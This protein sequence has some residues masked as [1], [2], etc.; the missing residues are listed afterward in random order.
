[1]PCD[2]KNPAVPPTVL[3]LPS[4]AALQRSGSGRTPLLFL[5]GVGGGAWSWEPQVSALDGVTA[6]AWEARGHGAADRVADA[7][8]AD[9]HAD[10]REALDVVAAAGPAFVIGHSMGGL[11]AM[12][13]AAERPEAIRG[14][15]LVDPVY[16]PDGGTHAGG[17]LAALARV[18]L[19]PLV[20]DLERNGAFSRALGRFVFVRSFADRGCMERAWARQRTQIPF[21]YPKMMFEAFDGTAGFP[22]RAFAREFSMPTLLLEPSASAPRFPTLLA[23]LERLDDR[24]THVAVDGGHYLQLD[25]SADDVSRALKDFV[26]RWSQ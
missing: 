12:A 11:L 10:A 21:E 23:D 19:P 4:G 15:C 16:A 24:F 20:R 13:L 2:A 5:H 8:L 14:L 25:R 6:Y 18:A 17:L 26:T 9:Y 22:N 3:R 1:M 7:G